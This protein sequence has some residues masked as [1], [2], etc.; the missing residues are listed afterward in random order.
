MYTE[1]SFPALGITVN[2]PRY[3]QLGPLTIYYYGVLIA[4]GLILAVLYGCKRSSQ[5]G[6]KEDDLVDG[7]LW[8][9]PFAIICAHLSA[10]YRSTF[11]CPFLK[12]LFLMPFALQ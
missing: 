6:I 1:I 4:F 2:P 8:V 11:V 12:P 9:T 3:L 7:V 10:P 5:F